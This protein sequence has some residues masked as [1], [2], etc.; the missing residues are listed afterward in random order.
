MGETSYLIRLRT[1]TE[2]EHAKLLA[3]LKT[4]EPKSELTEK[5]FSSVGPVLGR[6]LF[7]KGIVSLIVVAI[8]ILIYVA[9]VFRKVSMVAK[10][11]AMV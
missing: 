7:R 3:D 10:I 11:I 6:E 2:T 8:L 4:L 9:I 1:L 5:R